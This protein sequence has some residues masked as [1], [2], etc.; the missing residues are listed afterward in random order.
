MKNLTLK[1]IIIASVV[2]LGSCS[3]DEAVKPDT[4]NNNGNNSTSINKYSGSAS[5]GDLVTFSIDKSNNTYTL[6]NETFANTESGSFEVLSDTVFGGVYGNIFEGIYQVVANNDTFFAVE[7][8]DK[9]IAANFPS[10]NSNNDISF[11][12]S[13]EIDNSGRQSEIAGSYFYTKLGPYLNQGYPMEWGIFTAEGDSLFGTWV[14]EKAPV[15]TGFYIPLTSQN[16]DSSGTGFNYVYSINNDRLVVSDGS[17]TA[18][19]YVYIGGNTSVFL[20]D[21]GTGAGSVFAYKMDESWL[22]NG[23][24]DASIVGDYKYVDF[25]TDGTKG[26]GN[27]NISSSGIITASWTD[28]NSVEINQASNPLVYTGY[29]NLYILED[30]DGAGS[31]IYVIFAGDAVMYFD[32]DGAGTFTGYGTGGKLG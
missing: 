31:D 17:S 29:P 18:T 16:N 4:N 27:F 14:D 26:A 1:A 28:G 2:S 8:D 5:Y 25:E 6:N 22:V 11:G 32:F 12:V 7:L 19:G 24:D 10:G 13:S 23:P 21:L 3:E 20:I 15:D 9:I 30:Y